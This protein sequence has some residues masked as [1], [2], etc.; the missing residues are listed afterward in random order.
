MKMTTTK[1]RKFLQDL[2]RQVL[3]DARKAAVGFALANL[4]TVVTLVQRDYGVSIGAALTSVLVA[5][6]VY[7]VTNQTN[8]APGAHKGA[9]GP[10]GE[11]PQ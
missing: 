11:P 5:L 9:F 1:T 8:A 4:P 2:Q 3:G 6:G 10:N 7:K